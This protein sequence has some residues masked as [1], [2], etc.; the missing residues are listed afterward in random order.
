MLH[1]FVF[2]FQSKMQIYSQ[3]MQCEN[4]AIQFLNII[5]SFKYAEDLILFSFTSVRVESE[6]GSEKHYTGYSKHF[7][8]ITDFGAS[9]KKRRET[10]L[11]FP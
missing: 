8:Y 3:N 9:R 7:L 1:L 10:E 5:L 2:H 11:N 4:L 6:S